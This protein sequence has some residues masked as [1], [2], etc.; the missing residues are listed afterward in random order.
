M[1]ALLEAWPLVPI[2]L[3]SCSK[4][5]VEKLQNRL[6]PTLKLSL[7]SWIL[8]IRTRGHPSVVHIGVVF[9]MI[10]HL[11]STLEC[12]Q[13]VLFLTARA[14]DNDGN[15]DACSVF[16]INKCWVTFRRRGEKGSFLREQADELK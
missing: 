13:V 8:K 7:L 6:V 5:L 3:P 9:D 1:R 11:K 14:E 10:R 4:V 15:L 12:F 2:T 16:R